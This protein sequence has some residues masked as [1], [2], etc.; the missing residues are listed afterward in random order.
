MVQQCVKCCS[1]LVSV[2]S[3]LF[4]CVSLSSVFSTVAV[5]Q[6]LFVLWQF[7]KSGVYSGS[8][9]SVVCTVLVCQVLFLL[10]QCVKSCLYGGSVSILV[11]T[12]VI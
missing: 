9:L 11:C 5:C 3:G 1:Y 7:K 2:S 10:W 8:V 6:V 4:Y 12:V